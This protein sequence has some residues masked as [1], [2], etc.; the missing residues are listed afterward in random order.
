MMIEAHLKKIPYFIDFLTT[1][2]IVNYNHLVNENLSSTIYHFQ[3]LLDLKDFFINP[4]N[5]EFLIQ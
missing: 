4:N 1:H 5:H 2:L 3:K